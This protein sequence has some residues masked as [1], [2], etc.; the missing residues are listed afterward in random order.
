MEAVDVLIFTSYA[1]SLTACSELRCG[2]RPSQGERGCLVL[3]FE[4]QKAVR[5][6]GGALASVHLVLFVRLGAAEANATSR[7][8]LDNELRCDASPG[9]ALES[10]VTTAEEEQHST[11]CALLS[12]MEE[13]EHHW[14]CW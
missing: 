11:A 8:D 12:T 1:Q 2:S 9:P 6:L 14:C 7:A 5:K 10:N 4:V 3:S 13:Y